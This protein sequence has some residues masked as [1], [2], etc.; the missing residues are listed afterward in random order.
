MKTLQLIKDNKIVIPNV[1]YADSFFTRMK[2]LMFKK[3][4]PDDE[5]LLIEPCNQIHTFNM[6]FPMDAV[7]LSDDDRVVKIEPSIPHGKVCK[8]QKSAR[9]VLELYGG[10]AEKLGIL[11]NDMVIFNNK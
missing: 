9:K 11:E 4:L 5:G 8:T 10:V 7:Y 6:K 1:K 3:Q 2:G